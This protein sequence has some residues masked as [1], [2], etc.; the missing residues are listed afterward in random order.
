M[1]DEELPRSL[2]AADL[3]RRAIPA[4]VGL[5]ALIAI[6]LIAPGLGEVRERLDHA[7]PAWL[8]LATLLE[9]L[10]VASYTLMFGPVFCVGLGRRRAWQIGGSE[11]ALGSLVPSSGIAGL[12]LGAWVLHR[13][14][15]SGE[16][17][18][19]RSVAFFL[20]SSAANFAAVATVGTLLAVG[21]IGPEQPLALTALPAA[22]ALL[23]MAAI[24]AVSRTDEGGEVAPDASRARRAL[25][26]TR[27]ALAGGSAEAVGLLR[28]G[29]VGVLLGSLGYWAFDNAVLWAAFRAFHL[30]PPISVV[31]MGYLLGQLGGLIPVPGGIGGLDG[32]LIGALVLYGVPAAGA[33]AAVLAYRLV[34]F[35][36][37]LLVGGLAFVSLRRD[38]PGA[39][40]FAACEAAIG[41][42]SQR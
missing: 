14:G 19:R 25:A 22:L 11:L 33:T 27:R 35:W 12:G 41:M 9:V 4:F 38:M 36:V 7:D 37:P 28:R 34:L 8:V 20:I 17:I 3:G 40:E 42:Q 39:T 32:G 23:T 31:L 5:A 26:V 21:V 10:S 2:R 16:R 1:S 13:G 29:Q 30:E 15:M 6:V 24:I 18:S